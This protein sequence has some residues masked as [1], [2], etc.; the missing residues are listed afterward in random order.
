V[1]AGILLKLTFLKLFI[2]KSQSPFDFDTT[3]SKLKENIKAEGWLVPTSYNYQKMILDAGYN[4][5]NRH[6]VIELCTPKWASKLLS[7][8]ETKQLSVMLPCVFTVFQRTDGKVFV[9]WMNNSFMA[10][11]IGGFIGSVMGPASGEEHRMLN[12][13]FKGLQK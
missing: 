13:L 4:D 2:L 1:F 8:D 3:V 5:I 11:F 7:K 12:K 9:A 10:R 6:E